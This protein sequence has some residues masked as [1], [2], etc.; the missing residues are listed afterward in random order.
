MSHLVLIMGITVHKQATNQPT[1]QPYRHTSERISRSA[2]SKQ[3]R[4]KRNIYTFRSSWI[5][6]V[7]RRDSRFRLRDSDFTTNI[8]FPFHEIYMHTE[9]AWLKFQICTFVNKRKRTKILQSWWTK[10]ELHNSDIW[11]QSHLL[12]IEFHSC[13]H[14]DLPQYRCLFKKLGVHW[15]NTENGTWNKGPWRMGLNNLCMYNSLCT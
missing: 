13:K 7:L 14:S 6:K 1:N 3:A 12:A 8:S 10:R 5:R 2:L 4:L 11:E 15:W 9:N